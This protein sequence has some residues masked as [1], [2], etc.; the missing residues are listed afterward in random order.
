MSG[1]YCDVIRTAENEGKTLFIVGD[2]SGKGVAASLLMSQLHAIFRSLVDS[3][4]GIEELMAR[5]NRMLSEAMHSTHFV[6]LVCVGA[7][8]EGKI[9]VCNA[10]HPRPLLLSKGKTTSIDCASLPLG[11]FYSGD[12][13][14]STLTLEQGDLLV[15]Y[16]DGLTESSN[17]HREEY[18]ED[19]LK[20]IIQKNPNHSPKAVIASILSDL[21]RFRDGNPKIDDLTLMAIRRLPA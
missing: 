16:T 4:S 6:T 5:A 15:L 11:L 17:S 10:G 3:V 18:G 14:S 2:V 8:A 20:S 9:Q 13:G 7:H 19:R 21:Q 1:D 12:Y